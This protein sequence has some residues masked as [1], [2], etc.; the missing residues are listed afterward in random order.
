[1]VF[2]WPSL[3]WLLLIDVLTVALAYLLFPYLWRD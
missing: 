2:L 3:L 1:M